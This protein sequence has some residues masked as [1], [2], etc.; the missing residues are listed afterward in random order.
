MT[1]GRGCAREFGGIGAVSQ[2]VRPM[3][4][5]GLWCEWSFEKDVCE[6]D[7]SAKRSTTSWLRDTYLAIKDGKM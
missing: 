5:E 3:T 6:T 4:R 7:L 2:L 1:I